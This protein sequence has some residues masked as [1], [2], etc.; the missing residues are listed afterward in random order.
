MSVKPDIRRG[1]TANAP[2]FIED[3]SDGGSENR[4]PEPEK[5]GK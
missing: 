5:A 1:E 4:R 3:R 2:D